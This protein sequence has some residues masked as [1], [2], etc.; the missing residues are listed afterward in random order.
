LQ[1]RCFRNE[2]GRGVGGSLVGTSQK[3]Q[4]TARKNI[5]MKTKEERKKS[6]TPCDGREIKEKDMVK[7][8]QVKEVGGGGVITYIRTHI[9]THRASRKKGGKS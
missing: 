5:R 2:G 9:V 6:A 7:G 3:K 8:P 1:G 4:P